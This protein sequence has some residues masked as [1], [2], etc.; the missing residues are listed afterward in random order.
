V[1]SGEAGSTWKVYTLDCRFKT[2][3]ESLKVTNTLAYYSIVV[4]A[5]VKNSNKVTV[6]A[7][8]TVTK[9]LELG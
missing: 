5:T 9:A 7:T 6:R 4:N 3:F 1:F 2:N 8:E